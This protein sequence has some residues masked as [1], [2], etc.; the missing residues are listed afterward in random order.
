MKVTKNNRA[1]YISEWQQVQ[2]ETFN[3]YALKVQAMLQQ[4]GITVSTKK[5]HNVVAGTVKD[6]A[7]LR[8]I[9]AVCSHNSQLPD[10]DNF[11]LVKN[12]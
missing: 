8:T 1:L 2:G 12:G 6:F 5:I 11:N 9:K 3:G 10:F 7:I 4:Q